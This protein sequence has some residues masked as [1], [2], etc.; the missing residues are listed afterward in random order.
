MKKY[1]FILVCLLAAVVSGKAQQLQ[2]S[3][4]YDLQGVYHN[5]ST[6]GTQGFNFV[7]A[8]YRTQWSGFSGSPKT[9]TV[10]GSF[11]LP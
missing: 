6:A 4:M 2:T 10:F 5:P 11:E 9:A 8:S 3:S 7:G 1:Q